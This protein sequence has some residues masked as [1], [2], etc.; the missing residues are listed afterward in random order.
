MAGATLQHCDLDRAIFGNTV[1][2]GAD[3]STAYNYSIDPDI[4]RLKKARFAAQGLAGLL[5]KYQIIIT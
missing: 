2:E 3:L 5:G 1:L 4:N